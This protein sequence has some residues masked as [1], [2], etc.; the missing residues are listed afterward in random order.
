MGRVQVAASDQADLSWAQPALHASPPANPSPFSLL[1]PPQAGDLTAA[2]ACTD[3]AWAAMREGRNM[4]RGALEA[5][6]DEHRPAS[7]PKA[8]EEPKVLEPKTEGSQVSEPKAEGPQVSESKTE[9]P[10]VSEP[11]TEG[12]QVS[13]PKAEEPQVSEPR[14]EEEV[15]LPPPL[16]LARFCEAWVHAGMCTIGVSLME[17]DKR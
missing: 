7:E 17:R 6:G 8:A 2:M 10:Q 3:P 5:V 4:S 1:L 12:P 11:K 16:F 15:S 9:G 13:E 14:A